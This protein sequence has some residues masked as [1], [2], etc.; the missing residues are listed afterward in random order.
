MVV[1]GQPNGTDH[2][3]A[4]IDSLLHMRP[5]SPLPWI[6]L[7]VA[8]YDGSPVAKRIIREWRGR[9]AT[10]PAYL[11]GTFFC[12]GPALFPREVH[13]V[14]PKQNFIPRFTFVIAVV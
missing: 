12:D 5:T 6:G 2:G 10:C 4:T 14:N 3:A 11:R 1:T 7:F 13:D 9:R 8:V